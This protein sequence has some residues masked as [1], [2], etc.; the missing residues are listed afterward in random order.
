MGGWI[1]ALELFI[2]IRFF[3]LESLP[4][5]QGIDLAGLNPSRMLLR[6][7][8]VAIVIGSAYFLLDRTL[9][10][11]SIRRRPYGVMIALQTLGNVG[12]VILVLTVLSVIEVMRGE[13]QGL[14]PSLVKRLA[15]TNAIIA[16]VY[17]MLVSFLFSFL[18]T[19]DRK[20]GPGNLW[21]LI[22][23]TQSSGGWVPPAGKGPEPDAPGQLYDLD[24]D[25][26]ETNDLYAEHPEVV[27][28][29][30]ALLERYRRE[31]RSRPR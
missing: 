22:V 24:A 23:G 30:A 3:G 20:F 27:A 19:V 17:V 16:L 2:L 14:V 6:G 1:A 15:S 18:K 28:R 26:G 11:P 10:R 29:L 8:F 13:T 7:L 25:P 5:F 31:G 4:Q 21:K 12:L 9:D